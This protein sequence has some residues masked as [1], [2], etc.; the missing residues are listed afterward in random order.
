MEVRSCVWGRVRCFASHHMISARRACKLAVCTGPQVS[1]EL[2]QRPSMTIRILLVCPCA[3][4]DSRTNLMLKAPSGCGARN[5]RTPIMRSE[6]IYKRA[7]LCSHLLLGV[8]TT[9]GINSIMMYRHDIPQP[10]DRKVPSTKKCRTM[11]R[12]VRVQDRQL[13]P[14]GRAN[15]GDTMPAQAVPSQQT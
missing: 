12:S 3:I 2:G 9:N 6:L 7:T 5:M 11:Q 13:N 14:E 10:K 8:A 15:N 1:S 4:H